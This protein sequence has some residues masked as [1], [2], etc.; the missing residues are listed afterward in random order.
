MRKAL[1][2]LLFVPV[3]GCATLFAS[4]STVVPMNSDPNGAE[5][6][7]DG[8]RRGTTP[9][10]L[11]LNHK[12]DYTVV[13]KREGHR[14]ATCQIDR[15]VGAGWV[16]LDILGG[17]LPVIIDAATGAWHGLKVK[18]C[19]LNLTAGELAGA[20]RQIW[21]WTGSAPADSMPK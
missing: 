18:N 16:V 2:P 14:D 17:L 10:S 4:K 15:S 21:I 9:T 11:D 8:V 19:S 13:F 1:L 6:Y 12:Q 7:I 3:A 5:V 20:S